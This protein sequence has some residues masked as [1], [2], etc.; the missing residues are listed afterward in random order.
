MDFD[1]GSNNLRQ[2]E[3]SSKPIP[4][5][6]IE[7]FEDAVEGSLRQCRSDN[8]ALRAVMVTRDGGPG[9]LIRRHLTT[10]NETSIPTAPL[11][12]QRSMILRIGD[13]GTLNQ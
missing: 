5:N 4:D 2:S 3:V 9:R 1:C 13:R 10:A 6:L 11:S 8:L 7:T 12:L